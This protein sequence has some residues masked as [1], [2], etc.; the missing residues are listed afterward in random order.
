MSL[1][2]TNTIENRRIQFFRASEPLFE[3]FGYR[4]TTVEDICRAAQASKRTFYELFNNKSDLFARLL[5]DISERA[6]Q[7][8]SANST[9]IVDSLLKLESF[10]DFYADNL[11]VRPI[12]QTVFGEPD[13]ME[14]FADILYHAPSSPVLSSLRNILDEGVKNGSFRPLNPDKLLWMI[15]ALLDSMYFLLPMMTKIAGADEDKELAEELRRFIIHGVR[16]TS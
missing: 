14:K 7:S 10:I 5:F 12:F 3:R 11:A 2:Q 15:Y 1:Q 8:W 9:E 6:I 16:R 4:K 13:V